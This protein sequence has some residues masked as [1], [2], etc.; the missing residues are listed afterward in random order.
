MRPFVI[1]VCVAFALAISGCVSTGGKNQSSTGTVKP[2]DTAAASMKKMLENGK[3][4]IDYGSVSEGVKQLVSVLATK[5]SLSS[6]NSEIDAVARDA[7]AELAK[8]KGALTLEAEPSQWIDK[9]LNQKSGS[10]ID[11]KLQ[12]SILLTMDTGIGRSIVAN[13][14]VAFKFTKGNGVISTFVNTNDYGQADCKIVR[15]NNPKE[16]NIIRASLVVKEKDFT[17]EFEGVYRDFVY[18]PPTRNA[19]ILVLE[20]SQVGTSNDP[21][22][23]DAVFNSLKDLDFEFS[24]FNGSLKQQEFTKVFSG[25]KGA[26][27]KLG[28]K[29]GVSYLVAVYSECYNVSQLELNGKKYN[30]Y[31]SEARATTRVIRAIDG[32][33]LYDAK[34]ERDKLHSK[35]GQG[36]TIEKA[37]L[38]VLSLAKDEMAEKLKTDF[39]EINKAFTGK[40]E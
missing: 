34:I 35:H 3:E 16:E 39:A 7:E 24:V 8:V 14:P 31:V 4:K 13:M 6:S 12:P 23:A 11:V 5:A 40:E 33:V 15:F 30:M 38:N 2:D 21:A 18:I 27:S 9:A 26:I 1:F 36:N 19:T 29:E 25:D 22:I 20:T 10:T 37:I 17:Y 28:L 32:K